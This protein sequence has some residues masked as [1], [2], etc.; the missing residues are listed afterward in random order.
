[1]KLLQKSHGIWSLG[2]VPIPESG[3]LSLGENRRVVA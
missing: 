2:E 1:L 3:R